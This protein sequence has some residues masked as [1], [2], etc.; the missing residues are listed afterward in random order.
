MVKRAA[1]LPGP[2]RL[3]DRQWA[4]LSLFAGAVQFS[5]GMIIAEAVDPRYSVSENYISDLGVRAGAFVFNSSI[6]VLGLAILATSWFYFRAFKDRILTSVFLLAGI[7]AIGVGIFNE[8]FDILHS[9]FSFITFF[10]AALSAIA[11]FR[12][13]RP[14]F[15]YLSVLMGAGSLV[16]LGLFL[17]KN[18]Y[19]KLGVGGMERMIV[20]PVLTWAIGFGGYLLGTSHQRQDNPADTAP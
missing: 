2:V 16:A 3:D 12:I 13:L 9:L 20:Y 1:S 5:I 19:F 15:S 11:A 14:P 18:D 17:S 7:G 6:M 8:A 4:G 10:F